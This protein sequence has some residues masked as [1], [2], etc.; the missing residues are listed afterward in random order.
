M[1]ELRIRVGMTREESDAIIDD[2]LRR[3]EAGQLGDEPSYISFQSWEHLTS[4]L[5]PKR[6]ELLRHVHRTPTASIRQLAN[7][8]GRSYANV[9]ADVQ[10][11]LQAGLIDQD[12]NGLHAEYDRIETQ[13]TL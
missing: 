6:L 12:Q 8:L 3:A 1:T 9:H 7:R 2:A 10:V 4:V 11:L 13:M 5:S